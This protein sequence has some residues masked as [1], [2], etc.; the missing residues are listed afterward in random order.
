MNKLSIGI[1]IASVIF[2]VFSVGV[3]LFPMLLQ[4]KF[5]DMTDGDDLATN[6]TI[7][8]VLFLPI[9]FLGLFLGLVAF[10]ESRVM[11]KK[12]V[13][14]NDVGKNANITKYF[15]ILF[16]GIVLYGA[17]ASVVYYW[18]IIHPHFSKYVE[19]HP[20]AF[21][22]DAS[23]GST[24]DD[25]NGTSTMVLMSF[26]SQI[27]TLVVFCVLAFMYTYA[28]SDVIFCAMRE[29]G[30]KERIRYDKQSG[31][32]AKGSISELSRYDQ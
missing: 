19:D 11:S 3:F 25:K 4:N 9:V 12:I 23:S 24:D 18:V 7:Y 32:V 15:Y 31:E 29:G 17:I 5:Q 30:C 14:G 1:V 27:A 6:F 16:G 2:V 8:W 10:I 21:V 20:D 28:V 22:K 26:V 13:V